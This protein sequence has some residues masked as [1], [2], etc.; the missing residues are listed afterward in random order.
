MRS[1]VLPLV[2]AILAAGCVLPGSTLSPDP[3][4][5]PDV[6]FSDLASSAAETVAN[7][8]GSVALS[9]EGTSG[10]SAAAIVRGQQVDDA[11]LGTFDLDERVGYAEVQFQWPA[12]TTSDAAAVLIDAEGR[13]QCAARNEQPCTVPYPIGGSGKLTWGVW[14]RAVLGAI[15]PGTPVGATV[16]LHPPSHMRIGDPRAGTDPAISFRVSDTG[17]DGG[18]DNIGVLGDG[19]LFT[20]K[21]TSTMRSTDD[22][23]TWERVSPPGNDRETLDPMLF[24]DSVRGTV[25]VDHLYVGCSVLSFSKDAGATWITNPAACGLPGD[26]H[27]KIAAGPNPLPLPGIAAVYYSFSSFAQGAWAAHSYDGGLTFQPTPIV[28][29]TDGRR[30]ANTGPIYA[31]EAN[32]VYVPYYMCDKDGYMGAGV[33]HDSGATW[34]FVVVAEQP[35]EC[36][37]PDPGLWSDTEGT[38]YLAYHREDGIY[39]AFSQDLGETW[40]APVKVSPETLLSF[41]HVDMVAGDAGRIAIVYR[42]TP[43]TDKGPDLADGW[44]AWH[45]YVTFVENA[46]SASPTIRTALVT[47]PADPVQRGPLCTGGIGC[48]GGS[49][50][51]VDFIDIAVGPDGRVYPT[52]S[53]GCDATCPTPAES[54]SRLGPVGIEVDGPRLFVDKAPWA[55]S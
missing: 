9:F 48:F 34:T 17:V 53:D 47:D 15:A 33:S 35:G 6:P 27:Q 22:G 50:N 3:S 12:D 36:T 24:V 18:E 20:Q 5:A 54:R 8:D 11:P 37:D 19:T 45:L 13:L 42:A 32:N 55:A 44:A 39:Y 16:I 4:G 1:R 51:L 21:G 43:D 30:Y 23:G 38:V 26:D 40:S 7:A 25:Y 29:L 52:F 28:G 10:G 14:V 2:A 46:T 31:D 49:R 41:V